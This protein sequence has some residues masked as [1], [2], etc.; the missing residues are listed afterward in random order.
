MANKSKEM[1]PNILDAFFFVPPVYF[2]KIKYN[3]E[4][5]LANQE[6]YIPDL[7]DRNEVRHDLA[8]R[9]VL[10]CLRHLAERGK[11]KMFVLTQFEYKDYL[12][13]VSRDFEGHT[14]PFLSSLPQE[15]EDTG[16]FDFLIIHRRHGVFAGVVKVLPDQEENEGD[17]GTSSVVN[18]VSSALLKFQKT[19]DNVSYL[20][21]DQHQGL[22]IRQLL[23]LFNIKQSTFQKSL[24]NQKELLE[25]LS[26]NVKH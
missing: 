11:E 7:P 10:H 2:N 17:V 24:A 8:M 19:C 14:L 20:M 22:E 18:E 23:V 5:Y 12:N 26:S 15:T 4:Q 21:S 6:V 25:V 13:N 9:H 3:R 16:S 1:Y